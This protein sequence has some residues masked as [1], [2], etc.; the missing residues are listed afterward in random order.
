MHD[1]RGELKAI[2]QK[3]A[4]DRRRLI[5]I[6]WAAHEHRGFVSTD[7]AAAIAQELGI[8]TGH[9]AEVVSFY[10]FFHDRPVGRHTIYLDTSI[11]AEHA[12]QGAVREALCR[13]LGVKVGEVSAD[14]LF[15]LL[16]TSCIGMSDHAPA[17]LVDGLPVPFL[18]P[19]RA[20]AMVAWLRAGRPLKD[21]LAG[22]ARGDGQNTALGLPISNHLRN[23][24][25]FLFGPEENDPPV[26]AQTA[27]A[28][29]I[30]DTV[31][32]SG[33]RGRG[34]AGF[35][36]GKKW[37]LCRK[38]P[39][40]TRYVVC[41]ADEGE[42]GTFKDRVLLTETAD[43]LFEGMA[44]AGKAIGAT[45]GFLYLRAEY[46]YLL[47]HLETRR[48]EFE[49]RAPLGPFSIRIQLGAGA[50]ICG[51]ESA[52]LES[53]EGKRGE[54]RIKPPFP[55]E[56]GYLG[57]PTVVNNVETLILAALIVRRGS[58]AFRRWGT[59]RSP[60]VRLLSV[61]GDVEFPGIYEIP[62]GTSLGEVLD[63]CGAREPHLVQVGGPSGEVV[64]ADAVE[65][66]FSYEDLST[67]GSLMVF[68]RDRDRFEILENFSTFFVNESCGNCAPC[69]AGN[70]VLRDLLKR[71]K[72]GHAR[73]EDL[74]KLDQWARIVSQTSRCGL[75]MTSPRVLTT[76]R[77]AFPELYAD[78]IDQKK[79]PLFYDFDVAA[80]TAE[81]DRRV[82]EPS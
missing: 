10:H 77:K 71:F 5:D 26:V 40:A 29:E 48:R 66:V 22:L 9:V 56:S 27:T 31:T 72:N 54:P 63:R 24:G 68:S 67:G 44:L 49:A 14:G 11:I 4:A 43:L 57:C 12:G 30:I 52:L 78:A 62:W 2:V 55:V 6:L 25:P 37:D 53:M 73:A 36:T 19:E 8:S 50:Y 41:N 17:A 13:E 28:D 69:R 75:G 1:R 3:F 74:P 59:E 20:V 79:S 60:G 81:Y 45:E 64:R 21:W 18:T 34:G 39:A 47:E 15:G 51:E 70:V 80:A 16:E 42:P 76:S 32:R 35:S 65:R 33:L 23:V 58:D 61:S 46:R 38:I 82:E 7:D